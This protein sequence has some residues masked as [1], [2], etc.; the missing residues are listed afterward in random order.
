MLQ[1]AAR[2][3]P[4]GFCIFPPGVPILFDQSFEGAPITYRYDWNGDGTFEE[5]SANP[6]PAHSFALGFYQP[7]LQVQRE[8][9]AATYQHLLPIEIEFD[10]TISPPP[11]SA[12]FTATQMGIAEPN[13]ADLSFPSPTQ[14]L[15]AYK[16]TWA[17]PSA[18]ETGFNLYVS[19]AG[20]PFQIL[21][22]EPRGTRSTEALFFV[23]GSSYSVRLTGFNLGGESA[24]SFTLVLDLR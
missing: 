21:T 7:I 18:N 1:F 12:A 6:V 23:K 3:C 11:P 4:A 13:T 15:V 9:Q 20:S 22:S 16:F 8:T 24:P 5:T 19:K 2:N 17:E 14:P 10:P